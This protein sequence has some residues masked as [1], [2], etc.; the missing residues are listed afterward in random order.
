MDRI[1]RAH[2]ASPSVRPYSVLAAARVTSTT[3]KNQLSREFYLCLWASNGFFVFCDATCPSFGLLVLRTTRKTC[4]ELQGRSGDREHPTAAEDWWVTAEVAHP[5]WTSD[6]EAG[7]KRQ[8][9]VEKGER[10][11][12][13]GQDESN[14]VSLQLLSRFLFL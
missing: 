13:R 2:H 10:K 5:H 9:T 11:Q 8:R 14:H 4:V 6:T 3:Q 12:E 7:R 1:C